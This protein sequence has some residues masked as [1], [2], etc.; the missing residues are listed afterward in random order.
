MQGSFGRKGGDAICSCAA[1]GLFSN[2]QERAM[3]AGKR[4][5]D[6]GKRSNM[7]NDRVGVL[8]F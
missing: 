1:E 6:P 3:A 5:P 7:Q 2:A 8:A 4:L